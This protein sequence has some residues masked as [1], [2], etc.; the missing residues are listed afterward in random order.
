[1]ANTHAHEGMLEATGTAGDLQNDLFG[2]NFRRWPIEVH[3]PP[4]GNFP[5]TVTARGHPITID[6]LWGLAFGNGGTAGGANT[7]YYAAVPNVDAAG[8]FGKITAN[9]R[10]TSAVRAV[11]NGSVLYIT[12]GRVGANCE[13][14]VGGHESS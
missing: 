2:G 7:L 8:L 3:T 13:A 1:A 12:G 10:G 14:R 5:G 9:V 6:G 4:A 11:L